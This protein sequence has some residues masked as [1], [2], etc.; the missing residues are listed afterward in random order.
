MVQQHV[1]LRSGPKSFD[2][3]TVARPLPDEAFFDPPEPV[4]APIAVPDEPGDIRTPAALPGQLPMAEARSGLSMQFIRPE[5][6]TTPRHPLWAEYTLAEEIFGPSMETAQRLA[7]KFP[8]MEQAVGH[9]TALKAVSE[10]RGRQL[11]PEGATEEDYAAAK[12]ELTQELLTEM[13]GP[14]PEEF[15][16]TLYDPEPRARRKADVAAVPG[17]HRPPLSEDELEEAVTS[18]MSAQTSGRME[19]WRE[20]HPWVSSLIQTGTAMPGFLGG[21]RL[22]RP[23]QKLGP[24]LGGGTQMVATEGVIQ[25]GRAAVG[26]GEMDPVALGISAISGAVGSKVAE[27]FMNSSAGKRAGKIV[28]KK[29][30]GKLTEEQAAE[31]LATALTRAQK[32]AGSVD[33]LT[34]MA[35]DEFLMGLR[36]SVTGEEDP[37]DLVQKLIRGFVTYGGGRIG[38]RALVG[39]QRTQEA[40]PKESAGIEAKKAK[41]TEPEK[42]AEQAGVVLGET[43]VRGTFDKKPVE[44]VVERVQEFPRTGRKVFSVRV[45]GEPELLGL[46]A[47]D[48]E[49]LPK[50]AER[51][52]TEPKKPKPA[53]LDE[54]LQRA[55]RGD[56]TPKEAREILSKAPKLTTSQAAAVRKRA[57]TLTPKKLAQAEAAA[58]PVPITKLDPDTVTRLARQKAPVYLTD[59]GA[60]VTGTLAGIERGTGMAQVR[61]GNDVLTR[62]LSDVSVS[63]SQAL[64]Q[65]A[66]RPPTVQ[67]PMPG[68][69]KQESETRRRAVE[70]NLVDS[71]TE[72]NT[73]LRE[74]RNA[75]RR[76]KSTPKQ[77]ARLK[78][79]EKELRATRSELSKVSDAKD[80][81]TLTKRLRKVLQR[82]NAAWREIPRSSEGAAKGREGERGG[83]EIPSMIY[84]AFAAGAKRIRKAITSTIKAMKEIPE[85]YSLRPHGPRIRAASA[86]RYA[87]EVET[88]TGTLKAPA[89]QKLRDGILA[90]ETKVKKVK[91]D[92]WREI[93]ITLEDNSKLRLWDPD[94]TSRFAELAKEIAP[95]DLSNKTRRSRREAGESMYIHLTE[96]G[97][98]LRLRSNLRHLGATFD[99]M[100]GF[101]GDKGLTRRIATDMADEFMQSFETALYKQI[102]RS[103]R[104]EISK[105]RDQGKEILFEL[106]KLLDFEGGDDLSDAMW[107]NITGGPK[108]NPSEFGDARVARA[109]ELIEQLRD[110]YAFT[111]RVFV[112]N[113]F[114]PQETFD[115]HAKNRT[116]VRRYQ[117]ESGVERTRV[118]EKA[119]YAAMY[120]DWLAQQNNMPSY[121]VL[122]PGSVVHA[123]GT[124][125]KERTRTKE[126]AIAAGT[127]TDILSSVRGAL[128]QVNAAAQ[129]RLFERLDES[130]DLVRDDIKG[131][132]ASQRDLINVQS[133]LHKA[134]GLFEKAMASRRIPFHIMDTGKET[135]DQ[136]ASRGR[137][138]VQYN[139]ALE[140]AQEAGILDKPENKRTKKDRE[141]LARIDR[142]ADMA[143]TL[144]D[145]RRIPTIREAVS[146]PGLQPKYGVDDPVSVQ[147]NKKRSAIIA[148]IRELE[149]MQDH[150][151]KVPDKPQYGAIRSKYVHRDVWNQTKTFAEE[152]TG[153]WA[154]YEAAH[155]MSKK[156]LTARSL[157]ALLKNYPGNLGFNSLAG[158][159]NTHPDSVGLYLRTFKILQEYRKTGKW[160]RSGNRRV[161]NAIEEFF[162]TGMVESTQAAIELAKYSGGAA[163]AVRRC[164]QALQEGRT[165]DAV[166][167]LMQAKIIQFDQWVL[168][169]GSKLGLDKL[170]DAYHDS[171]P[172]QAMTLYIAKRTGMGMLGGRGSSPEAA[173]ALVE[174]W[175]DY[176]KVPSF[177][178]GRWGRN[179]FSF[180]RFKWKSIT[181]TAHALMTAPVSVLPPF[182][183]HG[184]LA[185][186]AAKHS[187]QAGLAVQRLAYRPTVGSATTKRGQAAHYGMTAAVSIGIRAAKVQMMTEM[188]RWVSRMFSDATDEEWEKSEFVGAGGDPIKELF[189]L[190][191]AVSG[192]TPWFLQLADVHPLSHAVKSPGYL[193]PARHYEG[194]KLTSITR[195]LAEQNIYLSKV[196]QF[197]EGVDYFGGATDTDDQI[198]DMGSILLPNVFIRPIRELTKQ[199]A[200]AGLIS[201]KG[202]T[203]TMIQSLFTSLGF[204][205]VKGDRSNYARTMVNRGKQTGDIKEMR[206]LEVVDPSNTE[207]KRAL[208]EYLHQLR[209]RSRER[210]MQ[211]LSPED[212]ELLESITTR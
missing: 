183:P 133:R 40:K 39:T 118:D 169:K 89:V 27:R 211:R 143:F 117:D 76:V 107:D 155:L 146:K 194:G 44:G 34:D 41:V 113:G 131:L 121:R 106:R 182:V 68:R 52:R 59:K 15:R 75:R 12:E 203:K 209:Q 72:V 85:A 186:L 2:P 157:G 168:E 111:G 200:E 134:L 164:E 116:Y 20:E 86:L 109:Y 204:Q 193:T 180:A 53:K 208:Q 81:G 150:W 30:A 206:Y 43:R 112:R 207:M 57:G 7:K 8:E 65:R 185:G 24:V 188:A 5:V 115:A 192:G 19:K 196:G 18:W 74:L 110:I 174:S 29:M 9:W 178:S 56:V 91:A 79:I 160:T 124:F 58:R 14:F 102:D 88:V 37:E 31:A 73:A 181:G 32:T 138:W 42:T 148:R 153:I 49:I 197:Y 120:G 71:H 125:F 156:M 46:N 172:S 202:T 165:L 162:K 83:T 152:A 128:E 69:T 130:T 170:E 48:V 25:A 104:S 96:S 97:F 63:P 126:T 90:G 67:S 158:M 78:G 139:K 94:S 166:G 144:T 177:L 61:V 26:T 6:F 70:S 84:D 38:A 66:T 195:W 201:G 191:I 45:K 210:K 212:R 10:Q 137:A 189:Q 82:A 140:K 129:M 55:S 173:R 87:A 123:M 64:R 105:L 95:L 108:L 16:G 98:G 21:L 93:E 136:R 159:L 1:P 141:Q 132:P 161:D 92:D 175:Y 28:A 176:R 47:K 145:F 135:P 4:E 184:A 35:T 190:P 205:L 198:K 142:L 154:A 101:K 13:G 62:N 122:Y 147:W 11:Y 60:R 167:H 103:H 50:E 51:A 179:I 119:M 114:I 36:R 80:T 163:T 77:Q 149:S 171:D 187:R 127:D 99:H 22:F 151:V 23:L 33:L 100:R 199:A 54:L 3:R 17:I